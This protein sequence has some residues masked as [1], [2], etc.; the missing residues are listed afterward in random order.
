MYLSTSFIIIFVLVKYSKLSKL[1]GSRRCRALSNNHAG[2]EDDFQ[3]HF[4]CPPT[5]VCQQPYGHATDLISKGV[6]AGQWR[7]E[8]RCIVSVA[9]GDKGY[10]VR[11][12]DAQFV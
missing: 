12:A 10:L 6:N 1:R 8:I 2:G 11:D 4:Q 7:N 3:R 9:E 5:V